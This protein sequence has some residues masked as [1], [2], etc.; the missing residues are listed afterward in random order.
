MSISATEQNA[1]N[2]TSACPQAL[3]AWW[4][5]IQYKENFAIK[6]I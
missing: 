6:E 4:L 2:S 5:L 1:L 3:L